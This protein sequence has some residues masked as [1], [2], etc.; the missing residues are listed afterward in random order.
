[1]TFARPQYLVETAWLEAHLN[2]P[3]LRILDCTVF[4]A[5]DAN[6]VH[7]DSGRGAWTEGHIPRSGFADLMQDLSDRNSPLPFMM[8]PATQFAEAMSRYGVGDGSHVVEEYMGR[9]GG[10]AEREWPS[11]T[12]APGDDRVR[13]KSV[14]V[15]DE[16][17]EAMPELDIRDPVIDCAPTLLHCPRRK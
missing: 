15:L 10:A 1:M 16:Q 11:A 3:D 9:G 14:R 6:G 13:L 2:D 12:T 8:P 5:I 4:F 17:G 7:L